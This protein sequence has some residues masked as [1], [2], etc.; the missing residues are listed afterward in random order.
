[1]VVVNAGMGGL[2][3]QHLGNFAAADVEITDLTGEIGKIDIQGKFSALILE[4]LFEK[5]DD[6]LSDMAYFSCKGDIFPANRSRELALIDGTSV[7]LS[8]TGYTGEFGFELFVAASQ[9]SALWER[10]L[11]VGHSFNVLPCGLAARDSLRAGALLP[12]SHQDIGNWLFANTPWSFVLPWDEGGNA[13]TKQFVGADAVLAGST[14]S[15]TYGFAGYDPRKIPQTEK[16]AVID[17]DSKP[18]GVVL[19]CT[20]D[21]G[22]GRIGEKIVSV[23][24][25]EEL[26]RPSDFKARGL[27]CGF[28]KTTRPYDS[29]DILYLS[30]GKKKIKV[31]IRSEVR[32]DRTARKPMHLMRIKD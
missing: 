6:V 3:S 30:E 22:V 15:Y 10:L 26:G 11:D 27:S 1:M 29:G 23:A 21:M 2:V 32:P 9:T 7:L 14:S 13:F 8:R 18:V 28:L 4:A 16:T 25:P 12:L 24:T 19:T 17:E 20:T 31:E 5:P